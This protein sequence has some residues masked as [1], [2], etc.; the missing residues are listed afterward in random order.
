MATTC[1]FNSKTN[2]IYRIF[3]KWVKIFFINID[4]AWSG[5]GIVRQD[6]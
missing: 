1:F 2:S 3:S 4:E 6:T 5:K